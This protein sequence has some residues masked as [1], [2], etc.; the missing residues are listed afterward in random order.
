MSTKQDVIIAY[1]QLVVDLGNNAFYTPYIKLKTETKLRLYF[2]HIRHW[3][4][5][6]LV[7]WCGARGD[8][9]II[10][11]ECLYNIN[12]IY[13]YVAFLETVVIG[14]GGGGGGDITGSGTAGGITIFSDTKVLTSDADFT[15]DTTNDILTVKNISHTGSYKENVLVVN[16]NTTLDETHSH[17][18]CKNNENILV[19]GFVNA[20]VNGE[21]VIQ[22]N[23]QNPDGTFKQNNLAFLHTNGI[24]Y[25][26]P[27]V[28][29]KGDPYYSWRCYNYSPTF[30]FGSGEE[31]LSPLDVTIGSWSD[32]QGTNLPNV[33][34]SPVTY[35][36]TLPEITSSN[37]K[38]RYDLKNISTNVVNLITTN[39]QTFDDDITSL[40]L[41]VGNQITLVATEISTGVY[42]WIT[43]N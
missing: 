25:F 12:V 38:T 11:D 29:L 30:Q 15:Y 14:G 35:S 43:F 1:N 28:T 2:D 42:T 13:D 22:P 20:N 34:V 24:Y 6:P 31:K 10:A 39:S 41:G 7:E 33:T 36:I 17:I 4:K 8:E 16:S 26:L 23:S 21:Y 5:R 32:I 37:V 19:D 40:T 18:V 9:S 27:N 3:I